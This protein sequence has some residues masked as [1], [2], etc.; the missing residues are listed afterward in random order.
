M[1]K[2]EKVVVKSTTPL[3]QLVP[4][5]QTFA[6]TIGWKE[7]VL[8]SGSLLLEGHF[9]DGTLY[10]VRAGLLTWQGDEVVYTHEWECIIGD[11]V[12]MGHYEYGSERRY[13]VDED[14]AIIMDAREPWQDSEQGV[15]YTIQCDY[16]LDDPNVRIGLMLFPWASQKV[17]TLN[18][19]LQRPPN[20]PL[21]FRVPI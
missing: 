7:F 10:C 15:A 12:F 21:P 13:L 11:K 9:P 14:G 3:I 6:I 20:S 1:S 2:H 17:E 8:T 4:T 18:Q 16:N 19:H 5:P